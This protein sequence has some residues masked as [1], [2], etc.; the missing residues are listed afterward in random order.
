MNKPDL[1]Q[2][3]REQI[4]DV[5]WKGGRFVMRAPLVFIVEYLK[6]RVEARDRVLNAGK[7]GV[8]LFDCLHGAT[9]VVTLV[10]DATLADFG[11]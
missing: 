3:A 10:P 11:E 7:S 5:H 2:A 8:V 1:A 9:Y 6:I 4:Y